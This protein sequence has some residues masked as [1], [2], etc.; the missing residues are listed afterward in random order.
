MH[1][2]KPPPTAKVSGAAHFSILGTKVQQQDER[3][4]IS[5]R[6]L[7]SAKVRQRD[8]HYSTSERL[9]PLTTEAKKCDSRSLVLKRLAPQT[10]K[11]E[12]RDARIHLG[13]AATVD[14]VGPA[15][16]LTFLRH[17]EVAVTEPE[18]PAARR[19]LIHL[20]VAVAADHVGPAAIPHSLVSKRLPSPAVKVR[21]RDA[22]LSS[23]GGSRC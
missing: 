8:A 22:R 4:L 17:E 9:P 13:E 14:H 12:R 16:R 23:R 18:G 6:P 19:A 21:R 10:G 7:P 5:K 15:A 2:L 1:S 3:F 11:V 20:G